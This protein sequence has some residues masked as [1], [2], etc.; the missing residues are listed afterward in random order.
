MKLISLQL[1][2]KSLMMK[3]IGLQ[4]KFNSLSDLSVK[5]IKLTNL[6]IKFEC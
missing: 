2:F 3:L 5:L 4:K 1:K 6:P